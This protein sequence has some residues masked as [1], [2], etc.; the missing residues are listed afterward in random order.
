MACLRNLCEA[1]SYGCLTSTE[2]SVTINVEDCNRIERF[3]NGEA[4]RRPLASVGTEGRTGRMQSGPPLK[5]ELIVLI[6]LTRAAFR[7]TSQKRISKWLAQGFSIKVT[8]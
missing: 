5:E 2:H 7:K 6:I 1:T 3:G 8:R 4:A